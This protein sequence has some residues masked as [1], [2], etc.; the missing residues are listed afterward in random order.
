[1]TINNPMDGATPPTPS[2]PWYKR[3]WIWVIAAAALL[4]IVL[5]GALVV[6]VIA[7]GDYEDTTASE[8]VAVESSE[9]APPTPVEE[10]EETPEETTAPAG[11]PSEEPSEEPAPV[12]PLSERVEAAILSSNGVAN[13]REL[14]ATSP[15]F[16]ITELE[17]VTSGTVRMH[18][19]TGLEGE[20][21]DQFARW[22]YNHACSSVPE[23]DTVVVRDTGGVDHNWYASRNVTVCS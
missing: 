10:P 18:V 15:G 1:M 21:R 14:E 5:P 11:E 22:L 20:E 4:F 16:Y 19:Q 17:D 8:T 7:S 3:W 9:P 12:E 6:S 13:L 23:L 2:R